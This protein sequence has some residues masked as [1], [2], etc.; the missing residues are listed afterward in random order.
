[1][2]HADHYA[3]Q[4]PTVA[5]DEPNVQLPT[6]EP[7]TLPSEL[8]PLN[9]PTF[10]DLERFGPPAPNGCGPRLTTSGL[11]FGCGADGFG[12]TPTVSM[13]TPDVDSS[14]AMSR[15]ILDQNLHANDPPAP[16]S[17]LTPILRRLGQNIASHFSHPQTG[18]Q[19]DELAPV[20]D[21]QLGEPE[22]PLPPVPLL[23]P[24][25]RDGSR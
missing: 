8:P 17:P 1:M 9:V 15:R 25:N 20:P 16:D 18:E 14:G 24:A 2:D 3:D 11:F 10:P 13:S 22:L 21:V 19:P 7:G 23:P 6:H 4:I 5:L 12:I